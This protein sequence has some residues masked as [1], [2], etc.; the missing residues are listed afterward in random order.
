[1]AINNNVSVTTGHSS[2]HGN[3]REAMDID[4]RD[5]HRKKLVIV[6]NQHTLN[7]EWECSTQKYTST[8]ACYSNNCEHISQGERGGCGMAAERDG[9]MEHWFDDECGGA[10][11]NDHVQQ[12]DGE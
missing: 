7:T 4:S 9:S 2:S 1:M 8:P 11:P 3:E 5:A 12:S 6:W 10:E